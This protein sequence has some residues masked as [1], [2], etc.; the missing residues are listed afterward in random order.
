[1][2]FLETFVYFSNENTRKGSTIQVDVLVPPG[3]KASVVLPESYRK[4]KSQGHRLRPTSRENGY[5]VY[6]LDSGRHT[7]IAE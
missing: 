5:G 3:S 7:L 4:V 2:W 6:H 1:M